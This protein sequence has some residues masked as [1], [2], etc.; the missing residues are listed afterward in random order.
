MSPILGRRGALSA[1]ILLVLATLCL[2]VAHPAAMFWYP[3]LKSVPIWRAMHSVQR[4]LRQHPGNGQLHW[5]MA[6]LHTMAAFTPENTVPVIASPAPGAGL[7]WQLGEV[8]GGPVSVAPFFPNSY[9]ARQLEQALAHYRAAAG[10]LPDD[11][12]VT[13]GLAWTLD[14]LGHPDEAVR[15]YWSVFRKTRQSDRELDK[16]EQGAIPLSCEAA[17][18]LL[19][20]LSWWRE[21]A[22]RRLLREHVESF[23]R[24]PRWITPIA[25]PLDKDREPADFIDSTARVRFDLDGRRLGR[26]WEWITPDAAWLV[27]DPGATGVIR[28]GLQLFRFRHLLAL[29]ARRLCGL[30]PSGR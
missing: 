17:T 7:P 25:I 24:V 15:L 1:G 21:A 11:Q 22:E 30:E 9:R 16:L 26:T 19:E 29:P 3:D 12:S 4:A 5:M 13:L 28:S 2:A 27:W 6:R 14:Q 10:L 8:R 18:Y 20:H 23:E